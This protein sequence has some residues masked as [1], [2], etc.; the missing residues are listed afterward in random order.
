MSQSSGQARVIRFFE[1]FPFATGIF[2]VLVA[3]ATLG[4]WA[5]GFDPVAGFFPGGLA[6][7]PLTCV[8]FILCGT[9]LAL[10][11]REQR[12][13]LS[14]AISIALTIVSALIVII[15]VASWG[16]GRNL[17]IDL[18]LFPDGLLHAPWEPPG[19][20][21]VNALAAF[22]FATAGLFALHL[23]HRARGTIEQWLGLVVGTIGF[24]GLVGYAFGISGFYSLGRFTGMSVSTALCLFVLA[25]GMIFSR[26]RSGLP[27]LM[28]EPG[29]SGSVARRLAP[30][31][32]LVP[33]LLGWARL[34]GER[35]GWYGTSV[36][37]AVYIIA[38]VAILLWLVSWAA[39]MAYESDHAREELLAGEQAARESAE[40]ANLSKSN[41]LA[42]MSHELRTPLSAIIG[43]EEL[44]ADGITGP[45]NDAQKHQLARMKASAQ[46]LL[47]LIDQILAYSRIDAGREVVRVEDVD[48]NE[49]AQEAARLVEPLARD[50][51]L[52]LEVVPTGYNLPMATDPGK[53]RQILVNL[54]SNAVK[55]TA[56]GRVTVV[57]QH[58]G[59]TVRYVVRDTGIGIAQE[60]RDQIFDAFWQVEQPS[61]RR[62][63]GTGLGLSVTRRLTHLLGG[64]VEVQ[65]TVGSGSAFT[66]ILPLEPA[67]AMRA[68]REHAAA[69]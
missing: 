50:K 7:I 10:A 51:G 45:V 42:V 59:P 36:G 11:V 35:A 19:R 29:A 25:L 61:T 5:A 37:V 27:R 44:L 38:M 20:I 41:F 12:G 28:A 55:F 54:L 68:E 16:T 8:L 52:P 24:L 63:G 2:V 18:V 47:H 53:V 4:E 33:F 32:V 39:R 64:D 66:V 22:V 34:F 13:Q 3:V 56:S 1:Q 43:Y 49:L 69:S 15:Q 57:V 46:H 67:L 21:A 60:H 23:D 58:D 30:P 9:A 31:A 48:A 14:T 6:M 17:G 65:S 40:G 62:A 26:R